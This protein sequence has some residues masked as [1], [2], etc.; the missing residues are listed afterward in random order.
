VREIIRRRVQISC[1]HWRN[2][3]SLFDS[4]PRQKI[5]FVFAVSRI[6]LETIQS[7]SPEETWPG[8]VV[9]SPSH[10]DVTVACSCVLLTYLLTYLLHG[11]ES[12]FR[13]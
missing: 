10:T 8:H 6:V 13:N 11:A 1:I 9:Y 12:F 2:E 3:E 5:F 4:R 7:A